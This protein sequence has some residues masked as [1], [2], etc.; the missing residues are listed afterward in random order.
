MRIKSDLNDLAK[1][2]R[3]VEEA[4]RSFTNDQEAVGDMILA[5]NEAVTNIIVHG[6]QNQQGRIEVDVKQQTG[7][8]VVCLRDH[9]PLFDPTQVPAPDSD[10][11]LSRRALGGM[12]VH[13]M[14]HFTDAL[15]YRVTPEGQNELTLVKR[16]KAR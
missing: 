11:P 9:A 5:V 14:R 16:V 15:I 7:D 8:L 13:M 3:F 10:V 1:I 6:Y 12:G 4:A 2:R